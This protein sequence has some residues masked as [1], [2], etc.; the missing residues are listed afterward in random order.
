MEEASEYI[1]ETDFSV[2]LDA[3]ESV[4][5]KKNEVIKFDGVKAE[6]KGN[7]YNL[8]NLDSAIDAGWLVPAE[9][10]STGRKRQVQRPSAGIEVSEATGEGE[11]DLSSDS[12]EVADEEK[13]VAEVDDHEELREQAERAYADSQVEQP[14]PQKMRKQEAPSR[15]SS[16]TQDQST[17]TRS[18]K[19]SQ[20]DRET[21]QTGGEDRQ[22]VAGDFQTST[23]SETTLDDRQGSTQGINRKIQDTQKAVKRK[24]KV[25]KKRAD[26]PES[27]AKAVD[28]PG[29]VTKTT[30]TP[31][32]SPKQD[33]DESVEVPVEG[34]P[35]QK[36]KTQTQ[37]PESEK[38]VQ[39]MDEELEK[40]VSEGSESS[41]KEDQYQAIKVANPDLPD[42]DF[43]QHWKTRMKELRE[44]SE[45]RENHEAIR[46][47]YAVE[48]DALKERIK[49][50]FPEAF[51]EE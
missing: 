19:T 50:E 42:M 4:Q 36:R 15:E 46:A 6:I 38:G 8:H 26:I 22:V 49:D 12:V 14:D 39:R 47:V 10:H 31:D 48:S 35:S 16:Q 7:E 43:S 27:G 17:P 5:I 24:D 11:S 37:P 13:A 30:S 44:N 2:G 9:E 25:Q 23:N 51:E 32:P 3:E 40:S 28:Q 33:S 45:F 18:Q 29:Q 20:S 21:Q 34:T 41:E 1:A